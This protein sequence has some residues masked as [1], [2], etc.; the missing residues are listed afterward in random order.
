MKVAV[1]GAG[2]MGVWF[3]KFLLSQGVPVVVSDMNLERLVQ[4]KKEL[5]VDISD[6]VTA[7]KTADVTLLCV[8][9]SKFEDVVKEVHSHLKPTQAIIDTC[10]IKELPVRTMHKYMGKTTTLGMHPLFGPGARSLTGRKFILTPTTSKERRFAN[11]VRKWLEKTG[12]AVTIMSPKEH[13]ELMSVVLGL[14]HFVG[15]VACETLVESGRATKAKSVSGPS[16]ELLSA[17]ARKVIRQ[18]PAL[19]AE[20]QVNLPRTR[21]IE[22]LFCTK[23][24]KWLNLT[25]T[26]NIVLLSER[27]RHLKSKFQ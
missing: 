9:I 7:V 14:S 16:Y 1:V 19:Y 3:T 26:K 25:R 12:G 11:C 17:L 20:L 5:G 27:A 2:K 21:E 15:M 13:D 10:S 4:V 6:N 23:A 22:A 24:V 8:P 18:N